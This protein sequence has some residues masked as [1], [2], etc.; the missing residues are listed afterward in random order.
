MWRAKLFVTVGTVG[1][2]TGSLL[3]GHATA[4]TTPE[5]VSDAA[6]PAAVS[7]AAPPN[8]GTGLAVPTL[9]GPN[10]DYDSAEPL[11]AEYVKSTAA[12]L[13]EKIRRVL[14]IGP[15]L[16]DHRRPSQGSCTAWNMQ[17]S[18]RQGLPFR[19][20]LPGR[21]EI[22]STT[23]VD[24][25]WDIVSRVVPRLVHSHSIPSRRAEASTHPRQRKNIQQLN[26]SPRRKT[27]KSALHQVRRA[28]LTPRDRVGER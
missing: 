27:P 20:D 1:M 5:P 9:P 7:A 6:P 4:G 11:S 8:A 15:L 18:R 25:R 13:K 10:R 21:T 12:A 26:N 28:L 14:L 17:N 19:C 3:V 16:P 22:T 2:L 23:R 24:E